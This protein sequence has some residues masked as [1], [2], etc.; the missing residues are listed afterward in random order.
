MDFSTG[1]LGKLNCTSPLF[2]RHTGAHA[3][4]QADAYAQVR[5]YSMH[6]SV[7]AIKQC[8][9]GMDFLFSLGHQS[10]GL[11]KHYK[12]PQRYHPNKFQR[13]S[14]SCKQSQFCGRLSHFPGECSL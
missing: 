2:T 7:K 13:R 6:V 14:G 5:R 8:S 1:A 12:R 3:G 9:A 10:T 11:P 4:T